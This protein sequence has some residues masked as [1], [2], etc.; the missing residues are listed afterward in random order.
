MSS[1]RINISLPVEV[2]EERKE[3]DLYWARVE[4]DARKREQKILAQL[5]LSV[6]CVFFVFVLVYVLQRTLSNSAK[7]IL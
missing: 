7:K 4:L 2:V 1:T 3:E 5:R 6:V